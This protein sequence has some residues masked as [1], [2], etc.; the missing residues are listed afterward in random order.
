MESSSSTQRN[1]Q[2][3]DIELKVRAMRLGIKMLDFMKTTI[4]GHERG[5]AKIAFRI[6]NH[7]TSSNV[8]PAYLKSEEFKLFLIGANENY[9]NGIFDALIAVNDKAD[10]HYDQ[11]IVDT[12]AGFRAI[13][14]HSPQCLAL[15]IAYATV[16]AH[17]AIDREKLD[18]S[19]YDSYMK[20]VETLIEDIFKVITPDF[21]TKIN[22]RCEGPKVIE[23]LPPGQRALYFRAETTRNAQTVPTQT[24][25]AQTVPTDIKTKC[26]V[27]GKK[28]S[29]YCTGCS[30]RYYIC[31][32][33]CQKIDW[34]SHPQTC[35]RKNGAKSNGHK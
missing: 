20:S 24:V 18:L 31:S 12:F 4:Y 35:A 2:L 16:S 15:V 9:F 33:G 22:H 6:I 13:L 25:P 32:V 8:S 27:C 11:H 26:V 34:S 10:P 29:K 21:I 1:E 23:K 5:M 14:D 30:V 28:T 19:S 3:T 17:V 7:P